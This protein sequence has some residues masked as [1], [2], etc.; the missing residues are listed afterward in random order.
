[1]LCVALVLNVGAAAPDAATDHRAEDLLS[2]MTL[3]E[4]VGQMD[5]IDIAS[6][7]TGAAS[8]ACPGCFGEP[9]PAAMQTVLVDNAVGSILAGGADMPVGNSG[10]DLGHHL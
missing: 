8:R 5:Q 10:R 3:A 1:M 2:Q 6:V 4:K 9:D 7:T